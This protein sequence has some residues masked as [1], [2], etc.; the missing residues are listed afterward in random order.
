MSEQKL[1]SPVLFLIFNRPDT[2]RQVF[3]EIRKA[4]PTQLFVA[5]DGARKDNPADNELC[6]KTREIIRQVDWDCTVTT[7]FRDENLGCKYGVSSAIDWFFSCVDEGIILEDDCIP[8][9]SFFLFCQELLE[10]Y[11]DDERIM[12]ISG[13]NFQFGKRRSDYSYYFS[14][15]VH[16]WGWATWRRAWKHY[17]IDMKSW[18]EI[19]KR[20]WLKDIVKGNAAEKFWDKIFET[21]YLG[22]INTWDYQWVFSCW[23]Q[24][25]L[26]IL[27]NVNLVKNIGF[28]ENATHTKGKNKQANLPVSSVEVPLKNPD[29]IIIDNDADARTQ[30]LLMQ[31]KNIIYALIEKIK[32]FTSH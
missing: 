11:R 15:H 19:K 7:L 4:K 6:K 9:Q 2:T 28:D 26:T 10:K 29:F 32:N 21:T 5:A 27:P 1:Y 20:K 3:N 13:D 12:M 22:K 14:R 16:I 30:V 17:D 18:P 25:G 24:N 31:N 23:I 8:D